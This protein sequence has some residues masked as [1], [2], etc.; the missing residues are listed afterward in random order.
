MN[1]LLTYLMYTALQ[2]SATLIHCFGILVVRTVSRMLCL[3]SRFSS[4]PCH[5]GF[6][7][8]E[9]LPASHLYSHF[10]V[11]WAVFKS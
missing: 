7:V 6:S 9:T 5:D 11:S 3:Q 10:E 4:F 1:Y 8:K 2:R